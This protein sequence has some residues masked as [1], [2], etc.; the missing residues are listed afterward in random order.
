M[1]QSKWEISETHLFVL[2]PA[3][4]EARPD[5]IDSLYELSKQIEGHTICALGDGAAWPVQVY[6]CVAL[7]FLIMGIEILEVVDF[8]VIP[9]Q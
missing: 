7:Y 3:K 4:G 1:E 9:H 8:T 5:E 6:N 2:F